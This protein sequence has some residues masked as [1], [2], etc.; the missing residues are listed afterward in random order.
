MKTSILVSR[1]QP[2][3]SFSPLFL[4]FSFCSPFFSFSPFLFLFSFFPSISLYLSVYQSIFPLSFYSYLCS[5]S[6]SACPSLLS[7]VLVSSIHVLF[8][9]LHHALTTTHTRKLSECTQVLYGSKV[10]RELSTFALSVDASH[11]A[12][13]QLYS[14]LRNMYLHMGRL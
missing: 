14:Y 13:V 4:L 1:R 11:E 12:T 10:R 3:F 7:Y 2:F 5:C 6:V 9:H 8:C